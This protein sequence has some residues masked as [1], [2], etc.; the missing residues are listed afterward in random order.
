MDIL[1]PTPTPTTSTVNWHKT[2]LGLIEESHSVHVIQ[3]PFS[4]F[5]LVLKQK[6]ILP[7][8]SGLSLKCYKFSG[9]P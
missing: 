2:D 5:L 9:G 4:S 8:T 3:K 1:E 6:Q 7:M